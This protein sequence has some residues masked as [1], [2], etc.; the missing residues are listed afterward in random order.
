MSATGLVAA[1]VIAGL[2]AAGPAQASVATDSVLMNTQRMTFGSVINV[3][4][5]NPS[6][7]GTL[8]WREGATGAFEPTLTG[9]LVMRD[10]SQFCGKVAVTY[11]GGTVPYVGAPFTIYSAPVCPNSSGVVTHPLVVTYPFGAQ[12][13]T[14]VTVALLLEFAGGSYVQQAS[15]ALYP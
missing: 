2:F 9:T 15:L 5:G 7:P 13:L 8:D 11:Y 10:A 6:Q 1:A 14:K 12:P 3:V 4:T